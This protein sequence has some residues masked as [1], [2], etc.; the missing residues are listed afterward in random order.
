MVKESPLVTS[1]RTAPVLSTTFFGSASNRMQIQ[2]GAQV[3]LLQLKCMKNA[4]LTCK[5]VL[6]KWLWVKTLVFEM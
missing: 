3:S 2:R 5:Q 4:G 1:S 6:P